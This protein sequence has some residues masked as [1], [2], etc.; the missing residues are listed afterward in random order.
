MVKIACFIQALIYDLMLILQLINCLEVA[1]N[2][3]IEQS[4]TFNRETRAWER[5]Q[6]QPGT[7]ALQMLLNSHYYGRTWPGMWG[8]G[9]G[10][11]QCLYCFIY[12]SLLSICYVH[13][14]RLLFIAPRHNAKLGYSDPTCPSQW[15]PYDGE[16]L[17]KAGSAHLCQPP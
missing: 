5:F 8:K 4:T 6:I 14:P 11:G 12:A 1:V 7:D 3:C 16:L 17:T 15:R 2:S 13:N 10:V 9:L